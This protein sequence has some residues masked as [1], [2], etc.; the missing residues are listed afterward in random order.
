MPARTA[1]QKCADLIFVRGDFAR[2]RSVSRQMRAI[3]KD[4]TALIEPA[5]LDECYLDV[6]VLPEGLT[7]AT[8]V[9]REIRARIR[10]ELQLT[11]SAGVAPLKFV[12]KIASDFR[13]PDGLTVVHPSRLFAFL[14]P[15]RVSKIPGVGP[16]T[17][18]LLAGLGIRTIGDLAAIPEE[19]AASLFGKHGMRLWKRANGI[20]SSRVQASRRRKS[21][22]AERTFAVDITYLSELL[23]ELNRLASRVGNEI[24]RENLLARTVRIKVRYTDFTTLTRSTT[25]VMPTNEQAQIAELAVRLLLTLGP[26]PPV[27]LLGV[28]VANFVYPDAPRQMNLEF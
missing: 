25:L 12:A 5:S 13:K 27:R 19:K 20:D 22:S 26:L 9:A 3:L 18:N 11:A 2:Y 16:A 1:A 24:K 4:Y 8:A 17:D 7:T 10:D 6:T 14:H 28:G 15:M 21:R 23:A